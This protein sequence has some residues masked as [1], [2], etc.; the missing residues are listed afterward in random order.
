MATAAFLRHFL[1]PVLS[2]SG[3]ILATTSLVFLP[4]RVR[5]DQLERPVARLSAT[6]NLCPTG[7]PFHEAKHP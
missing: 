5:A 4:G 7:N 3:S 2:P 1:Y 6:C